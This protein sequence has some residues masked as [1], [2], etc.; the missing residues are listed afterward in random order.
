MV[1]GEPSFA[2]EINMAMLHPFPSDHRAALIPS[3]TTLA[4]FYLC[5]NFRGL[6]YIWCH[7]VIL[8]MDLISL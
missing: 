8:I 7:T 5:K 3:S 4:I 6:N 2:K 1:K